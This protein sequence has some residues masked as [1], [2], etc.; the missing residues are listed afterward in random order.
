VDCGEIYIELPVFVK[1]RGIPCV[2]EKTLRFSTMIDA[3]S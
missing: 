1:V 2:D 3:C